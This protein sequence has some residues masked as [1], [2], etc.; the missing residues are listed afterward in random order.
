MLR[1]NRWMMKVKKESDDSRTEGAETTLKAFTCVFDESENSEGEN[2][3]EM[4][5]K[6]AMLHYPR[7]QLRCDRRNI[8]TSPIKIESLS[9]VAVSEPA[10][11]GPKSRSRVHRLFVCHT[12]ADGGKNLREE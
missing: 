7:K 5:A 12:T 9:R 8:Y 2:N 3:L 6:E 11:R 10:E 1:D 4:W